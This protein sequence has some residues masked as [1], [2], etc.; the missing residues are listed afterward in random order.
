[1]KWF[2]SVFAAVPLGLVGISFVADSAILV[3]LGVLAAAFQV[4]FCNGFMNTPNSKP[5]P[6]EGT[7]FDPT[8]GVLANHYFEMRLEEEATRCARYGHS[9]SIVVLKP[10]MK[11]KMPENWRIASASAAQRCAAVVRSVDLVSVLA[12]FEF[13]FCLIEADRDAAEIV[14]ERLV[15][16]L[17]E[18][19]CLAGIAVYPEESLSASE[20]IRAAR[21]RCSQLRAA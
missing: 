8:S 5:A 17:P 18:Y 14:R 1:M 21:Q 10:L 20:L 16:A 6:T 2:A 19:S 9:M 12:P 3:V 11:G 15:Q 7:I 13:G 4:W